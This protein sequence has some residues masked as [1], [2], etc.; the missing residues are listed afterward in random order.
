MYNENAWDVGLEGGIE[1]FQD[2]DVGQL[3]SAA[4]A[5][6]TPKSTELL[7]LGLYFVDGF[8]TSSSSSSR[9]W[10]LLRQMAP[11]YP[12]LLLGHV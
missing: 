11:L 4:A 12:S 1:D 8:S 9:W 10:C 5:D 7:L 6:S 3:L 2:F